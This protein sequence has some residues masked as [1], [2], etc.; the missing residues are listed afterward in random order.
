[1]NEH[2]NSYDP[3]NNI[4]NSTEHNLFKL[5]FIIKFNNKDISKNLI[6]LN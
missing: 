2:T 5:F 4:G 3:K 1:V 6:K